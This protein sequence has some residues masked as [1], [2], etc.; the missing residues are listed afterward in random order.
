MGDMIADRPGGGPARR[1][2]IQRALDSGAARADDRDVH[3]SRPPV[4]AAVA[5]GFGRDLDATLA[6]IEVLL[7]G[8]RARGAGLVVLPECAL[9]GY[10]REPDA[11]GHGLDLPPALA[12]DGPEIARL[13]RL[14]GDLVVCA[15]YTEASQA[16]LHSSAVCVSGDGVLGH[17]RKVHLPPAERF[18]YTPGDGYAAFDTPA[19]RI[20]MLI[21]YDKLFPEAARALALDGADI[22]CS[23]AAW[24]VDR[25]TPARGVR[26]DRQTRHF[27]LTDAARAVE[28][29]VVWASSNQVGRWGTLRF[30]GGAKV[31]DP[32]GVTLAATGAREGIAAAAIDAR[33]AVRLSRLGIDH[34]GDRR[35]E[36]YGT[37]AA[38]AAAGGAAI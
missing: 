32:D 20:G 6:R 11:D 31:V 25:L 7:D 37:P 38:A 21:C 19:G 27:D 2:F 1:R 16:G 4:I 18:A 3:R 14:A 35:P 33:E 17:Q 13:A 15:G 22:V 34:L 9:G 28:N 5:A 10:L 23:L 36:A 26:D 29:Q 8:A 12:P 24:P 30:L